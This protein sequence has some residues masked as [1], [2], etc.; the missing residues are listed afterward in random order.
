MKSVEAII[1]SIRKK[2]ADALTEKRT[3]KMNQ[4]LLSHFFISLHV[5]LIMFRCECPS[6]VNY[7][8]KFSKLCH[9]SGVPNIN[10]LKFEKNILIIYKKKRFFLMYYRIGFVDG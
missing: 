5:Q 8:K 3:T 6:L 10:N 2:Y 7:R 1:P 9:K 4:G